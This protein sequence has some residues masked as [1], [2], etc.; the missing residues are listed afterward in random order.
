MMW[1]I[2]K[3]LIHWNLIEYFVSV[4]SDSSVLRF[5]ELYQTWHD[6]L[7]LKVWQHVM[8]LHHFSQDRSR[9]SLMWD[10][11]ETCVGDN[12]WHCLIHTQVG[13]VFPIACDRGCD[14]QEADLHFSISPD[15]PDAWVKWATSDLMPTCLTKR[16][17]SL[18]VSTIW[19]M[20][21]TLSRF[22]NSSSLSHRETTL[23]IWLFGPQRWHGSMACGCMREIHKNGEC[24]PS[25]KHFF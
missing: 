6:S 17:L 7:V 23:S 5:P 19:E 24:I 8:V 13:M 15:A 25:K 14:R 21:R 3:S 22:K 12:E 20:T 4:P 1:L 16:S 2:I 11:L 10:A 18:G 9:E